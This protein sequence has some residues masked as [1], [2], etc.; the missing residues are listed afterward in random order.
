[1]NSFLDRIKG[2]IQAP[3]LTAT[4]EQLSGF[5][6]RTANLPRWQGN[7]DHDESHTAQLP[8]GEIKYWVF[9]ADVDSG[10]KPWMLM[11]HGF[12]G[13]HHGLTN[14]ID[15][16]GD[17]NILV[18]DLPG[19]GSSPALRRT[20]TVDAY[21]MVLR[22][23]LEHVLQDTPILLLGHS[24][25]S[26]VATRLARDLPQLKRLI[27]VNPIAE[28]PLSAANK[29]M[30]LLTAQYYRLSSVLPRK[31][32]YGLLRSPLIVRFMTEFMV[33]S[34]DVQIRA[35]AHEQH[36]RFFSGF[37]SR[38]VLEE[39][40]EASISNHCGMDA[41]HVDVPVLLIAGELDPLGSVAAQE[42]LAELFPTRAELVMLS[43]VGHLIHYE[44]PAAAVAAIKQF[45]NA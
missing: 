26:I 45:L 12:R 23:L 33:E 21:A 43:D 14:L 36:A 1:M 5:A 37:A 38:Q 31:L 40:Y 6:P 17:Y 32:G 3:R 2:I 20:H 7:P 44:K 8:F 10:S 19:F 34:D 16:L 13:D 11:V 39:A 18:P 42:R 29:T 15:G 30:T 22:Q 24:F 4:P 35:L 25:G 27:L 28:L 41:P 9:P